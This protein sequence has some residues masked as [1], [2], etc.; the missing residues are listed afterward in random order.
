METS[1]IAFL[2]PTSLTLSSQSP[3]ECSRKCKKTNQ[4]NTKRRVECAGTSLTCYEVRGGLSSLSRHSPL[5]GLSSPQSVLDCHSVSWSRP[6]KVTTQTL[7]LSFF[8]K[9]K[10]SMV[11]ISEKAV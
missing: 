6:Y 3:A 9:E 11:L 4:R 10:F 2:V 5:S 8:K 1:L 7:T